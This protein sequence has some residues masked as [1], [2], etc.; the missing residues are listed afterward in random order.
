MIVKG[1]MLFAHPLFLN[2]YESLV[3]EAEKI[4]SK[5]PNDYESH[6]KVKLLAKVTDLI[7]D[8]I[9]S[10]PSHDTYNQGN[11]LGTANRG[12]KRAK[13]GR[14]RLFF[15]FLS[16]T[17]QKEIP[18][19]VIV[20]AWLNDERTIRKEGDKSDVYVVFEKKL[21]AGKPP[22]SFEE[23]LAES[24]KLELIAML[25]KMKSKNAE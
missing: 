23:L 15:R 16:S 24:R 11:T 13:F 21:R 14:C 4:M 3:E 18:E 6:P 20:Y 10:D 7:L 8:E 12:W 19:K 17:K 22:T 5:N 25:E 2:E 1:W 9:P